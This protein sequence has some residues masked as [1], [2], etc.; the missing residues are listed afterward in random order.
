MPSLSTQY[1]SK[2]FDMLN[3]ATSTQRAADILDVISDT[4]VTYGYTGIIITYTTGQINMI[5]D[6]II[7]H[8]R[9][10][11][12]LISM[13]EADAFFTNY[14][15]NMGTAREKSMK[16]LLDLHPDVVYKLVSISATPI[17]VVAW[18]LKNNLSF[19]TVYLREEALESSGYT[20]AKNMIPWNS[21]IYTMRELK[22]SS[23]CWWISEDEDGDDDENDDD[24]DDDEPK[25]QMNYKTAAMYN[26]VRDAQ[27]AGQSNLLLLDICNPRVK[28]TD[29]VHD[30][31]KRVFTHLRFTD[32]VVLVC[33]GEG[34]T[35]MKWGERNQDVVVTKVSDER[36]DVLIDGL[37]RE[38]RSRP[39]CVMGYHVLNRSVS[40]RGRDIVPTHMIL[41]I[42]SSTCMATCIQRFGRAQGRGQEVLAANGGNVFV[43]CTA[44]DWDIVNNYHSFVLDLFS[45]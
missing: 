32:W 23:N 43:L 7:K 2:A 3:M 13:D 35:T 9:L 17:D 14:E 36:I 24:D 40:I 39:I 28:A 34:T 16:L 41:S 44:A 29:N 11:G 31:A 42:S 38:T 1:A 33:T 21:M 12:V 27:L 19:S 25:R 8:M 6:K 18:H 20:F 45:R 5:K 10:P 26:A 4:R 15:L 30:R 37:Q 22:K